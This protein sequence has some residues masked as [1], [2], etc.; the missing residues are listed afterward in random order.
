MRLIAAFAVVLG[1]PA[2]LAVLL[3]AAPIRSLVKAALFAS[4]LGG[5]ALLL[6][7]PTYTLADIGRARACCRGRGRLGHQLPSRS[8]A[9]GCLAAR[10]SRPKGDTALAVRLREFS[11]V[12]HPRAM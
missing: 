10:E 5:L 4:V 11:N 2:A 12:T 9:G 8:A 3:Y 1:V 6:Y 7:L